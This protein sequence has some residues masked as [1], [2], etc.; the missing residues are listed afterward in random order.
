MTQHSHF[1]VCQVC[2]LQCLGVIFF[3]FVIQAHAVLPWVNPAGGVA[4]RT[5]AQ[6][7]PLPPNSPCMIVLL[8]APSADAL[9]IDDPAFYM[10]FWPY[11]LLWVLY[12]LL[13]MATGV[14]LQ[15]GEHLQL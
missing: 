1:K 14:I 12:A 15:L 6:S 5:V 8:A 7:L 4:K 3:G 11:L 9:R 10:A 13:V 2:V